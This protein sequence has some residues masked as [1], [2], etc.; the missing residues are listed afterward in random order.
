MASAKQKEELL[1]QGL[2]QHQAGQLR[3]AGSF[4]RRL[5]DVDPAN[6][7]ALYLLGVLIHQTGPSSRAAEILTRALTIAPNNAE[8]HNALGLALT[9]LDRHDEAVQSFQRALALEDSPQTHNNFGILL[10]KQGRLDEAVR[11]YERA[12]ELNAEF[13]DA[14]FNL[15]NVYRAKGQLENAEACYREIVNVAPSHLRAAIALGQVLRELKRPSEAAALLQKYSGDPE[16]HC[17]LGDAFLDCGERQRAVNEYRAAL[18]SERS[19]R[20]FYSLGCA[21]SALNEHAA[22]AEAFRQAVNINANWHEARH[23]LGQALFELGQVEEAFQQ[24]QLAAAGPQPDLPKAMMAVLVPQ[25]PSATNDLVLQTRLAWA[26]NIPAAPPRTRPQSEPLRIGYVSSFF[27]R[28]NWM[29][30]VWGLINAHAREKFELHL[31]ADCARGD[32]KHGYNPHPQDHFHHIS[33]VAN[34]RVAQT[35]ADAGIDVLIDLNGYSQMRRLPLFALRPAPVIVGWFNMFATTGLAAFDYLVGDSTVLPEAEEEF[36]SEKILRVPGSYLTFAV[37]YSVPAVTAAPGGAFTFGCLA[38]QYKITPEVIAAWS[39]ILRAVPESRMILKNTALQSPD[40][41][42]FVRAE[43][44]EHGI[45][46]ERVML[47]GPSDHYEFLKTYEK[48]DIALDTFPYNGGTTTTESLWQ[49]VPVIAFS[50][51]RW[52]SRTSASILRAANLQQFVSGDLAGYI[53]AAVAFATDGRDTLAQLRAGMRD[54]LLV[55]SVCDTAAFARNM[56]K[57][58]RQI[59][60][61]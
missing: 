22:A 30:P 36:Y 25:V 27:Q 55:S 24:F 39:R 11:E 6:A 38:P 58:Y 45:R 10:K 31:F 15:G 46:A 23:N 7:D 56:E 48:I 61:I 20:A 1:R 5:L 42:S 4:Y 60:P 16:I 26:D 3:E 51:D 29:K 12:I 52:V 14:R 37:N 57:L 13:A 28:D 54:H 21:L 17:E 44:D 40:N 18:G 50:G 41:R 32:I 49:G 34:D 53:T 59:A 33:G 35:I 47:E 43:F 19:A 2:A 9:N 8:C